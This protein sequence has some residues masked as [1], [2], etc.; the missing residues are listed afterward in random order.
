VARRGARGRAFERENAEANS[1]ADWIGD[2]VRKD[3][4]MQIRQNELRQKELM[5]TE[6]IVIDDL[7]INSDHVNAYIGAWFD[8]DRRF[9]TNTYG[10]SEYINLYAN[11]YPADGSLKIFFVHHDAD[12]GEIATRDIDDLTDSEKA[13]ILE[14]M[15]KAGLDQCVSDMASDI[16][17][18]ES[19]DMT[20]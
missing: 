11:Y 18:D 19:P 12:G 15:Q 3:I 10:T 1:Q 17:A 16:E 6:N 8:V 5:T 4:Y 13:A 14:L 20:M 2:D 9:D 7:I